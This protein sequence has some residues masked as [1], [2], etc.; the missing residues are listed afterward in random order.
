[1][2]ESIAAVGALTP[3]AAIVIIAGVASMA[4]TQWAKQAHWS[5][6]RTQLVAVTLSTILGAVAYIVSGVAVGIPPGLVDAA[7]MLVL[8]IAGVAVMARAAYAILG[9]VI[10]DGT[11]RTPTHRADDRQ[12]LSEED[13]HAEHHDVPGID[14]SRDA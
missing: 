6:A 2:N 14:D 13:I 10:P 8:M 9:R 5:K 7:S 12:I 4:L 1:M 3:M 11:E